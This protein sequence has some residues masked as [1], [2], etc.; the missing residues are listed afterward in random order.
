MPGRN[1]HP[2]SRARLFGAGVLAWVILLVGLILTFMAWRYTLAFTERQVGDRFDFRVDELVSDVHHRMSTYKQVLRGG[3]ALLDA[4]GMVDRQTWTT[5][6]ARL[7]LEESFPGIQGFG[8]SV[9]IPAERLEEHVLAMRRSFPDYEIRPPGE[10]ALYSSI[11]YLEPFDWRNQRAFGYDMFSEPVRQEAMQRAMDTGRAAL[12]STVRLV[13]ETQDDVQSGFLLYLPVYRGGGVPADLQA[14]RDGL[15]GWVYAPFRLED[16]M[17]GLLGPGAKDL[18]LR[19]YDG[20]GM[21]SEK[22]MY[23]SHADAGPPPRGSRASVSTVNMEGHSW[24]V[25]VNARGALNEPDWRPWLVLLIGGA[26]SLLLFLL[27][28]NLAFTRARAQQLAQQMTQALRQSEERFRVALKNTNISV[29]NQDRDLRYTWLFNPLHGLDASRIVGKSDFELSVPQPSIER[30]LRVLR[31]G[32]GLHEEVETVILN[33]RYAVELTLEP[34]RD[35]TG[36][37]GITAAAVDITS[38]KNVQR[39]LGESEARFRTMFENAALGIILTEVDEGRVVAVNPAFQEMLG[40]TEQEFARMPP[41]SYVQ[42]QDRHDAEDIVSA[43]LVSERNAYKLQERYL[44]KDGRQIVGSLTVSLV[45]DSSGAPRYLLWMVEDITDLR[46]AEDRLRRAYAELEER[47]QQRTA[48][49][50]RRSAELERSNAEL[51]QF[52]YVASHDLQ[53]PLRTVASFAQ[54]LERRYRDRLDEEGLQFVQYIVNGSLRMRELIQD[55]LAFSR[56]GA[57]APELQEVELDEVLKDVLDN[58]HEAC[59]ESGAVISCDALPVVLADRGELMQM[60]QNLIANAIKFRGGDAPR[61]HVGVLDAQDEWRFFV[62]DNGIGIDPE[63]FGRI[64]TI[65][66]RLHVVDRYAGTGIGLAICKKIVERHGGRIWVESH[67]GEGACFWFTLRKAAGTAA[68][69]V[70]LSDA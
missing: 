58:L 48:E 57:G 1:H 62:R 49:L 32:I 29:F 18:Q 42:S 10:R 35:E 13:Q 43:L 6:A 56:L 33:K 24:T 21:R 46:V 17:R 66:H 2:S 31:E 7:R 64:F 70:S 55:L 47:V 60:F 54:L 45:R 59:V 27:V 65:F 61:V 9:A 19:L 26:L 11:I 51:E 14:R 5:Y 28:W 44:R 15:L 68:H 52:A 12:S 34:L 16:F 22:L 40:Y 50:R 41:R 38:L 20:L 36:V 25:R 67:P 3:V 23:D 4:A 63:Q 30:K 69:A 39:E 53:E 37:I 8:F